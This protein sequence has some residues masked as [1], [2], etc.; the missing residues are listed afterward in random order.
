VSVT[1]SSQVQQHLLEVQALDTRLAQNAHRR[2]TLPERAELTSLQQDASVLRDRIVAAETELSDLQREQAKADNDVD[3]VR[4]R[5]DRD[6]QRLESGSSTPKELESLQH[7]IESLGRR[8]A[9]LEEIELDVMQRVEDARKALDALGQER[10]V[11]EE[12]QAQLQARLAEIEAELDADD[13]SIHEQRAGLVAGIDAPLLALYDRIRED[14][15]GV[16]AA[17]LHRG[18]CTGCRIA[19]NQTEIERL[20]TA[21][22]DAVLR[23]EECRR[24]LVRTSESGL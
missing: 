23:C 5:A 20:R 13:R 15:A 9:E 21:P 6:R 8:Q 18:Q 17:A 2:R 16:G 3:A 4:Q 10:T 1:A 7:E 19:L 11:N 12:R 22:A 14:Q 24:I